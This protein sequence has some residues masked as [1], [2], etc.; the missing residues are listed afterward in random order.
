MKLDQSDQLSDGKRE[1]EG[2]AE[3]GRWEKCMQE[4]REKGRNQGFKAKQQSYN[5]LQ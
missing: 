1:S 4:R 2:L 5:V 3:N